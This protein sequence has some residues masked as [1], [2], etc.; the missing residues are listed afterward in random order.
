MTEHMR[1]TTY[2]FGTFEVQPS[3][4]R[5]LASGEPVMLGPR[6]FDLLVALLERAGQLVTKEAREELTGVP[7]AG[8][9]CRHGTLLRVRWR[10][11]ANADEIKC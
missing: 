4:R 11:S 9:T 3:E 6:A 10:V 7:S 2:R 1:N 5:L 8:I